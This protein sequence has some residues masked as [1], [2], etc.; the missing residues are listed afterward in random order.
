[1]IQGMNIF[2]GDQFERFAH[3]FEFV[4]NLREKEKKKYIFKLKTKI[5]VSM[6]YKAGQKIFKSPAQKNP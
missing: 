6:L 3:Q 2:H 4:W 5:H 1:M